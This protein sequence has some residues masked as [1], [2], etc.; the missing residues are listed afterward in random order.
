MTGVTIPTH[1]PAR[2]RRHEEWLPGGGGGSGPNFPLGEPRGS[3][4]YLRSRVG[5]LSSWPSGKA[6]RSSF[7]DQHADR[8]P[9]P[10]DHAHEMT[11]KKDSVGAAAAIIKKNCVRQRSPEPSIDWPRQH[12]WRLIGDGARCTFCGKESDAHV[13]RPDA[14]CRVVFKWGFVLTEVKA[15]RIA[16]LGLDMVASSAELVN[17]RHKFHAEQNWRREVARLHRMGAVRSTESK[18]R[19]TKG[20]SHAKKK[21]PRKPGAS[22]FSHSLPK[23]DFGLTCK[24]LRRT[25]HSSC[26][27]GTPHNRARRSQEASSPRLTVREPPARNRPSQRSSSR[28]PRGSRP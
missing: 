15:E 8:G 11:P 2:P 9:S 7:P 16:K 4:P 13:D 20:P 24:R 6:G 3:H 12:P 25:R 27:C 17:E 10:P 26:G 23:A 1:R 5:R 19:P 21:R 28:L 22:D 14:E 18:A